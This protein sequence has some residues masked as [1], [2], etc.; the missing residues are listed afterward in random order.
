M[1]WTLIIEK[2]LSGSPWAM[3]VALGVYH[4]RVRAQD[5]AVIEKK[6]GVIE[7]KD[8]N[9]KQL[10]AEFKD[11]I[12]EMGQHVESVMENAHKEALELQETRVKETAESQRQLSTM[13]TRL[14]GT[15]QGLTTA[16]QS[17]GR[18]A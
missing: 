1:D 5:L 16:I 2:I 10:N 18:I 7:E 11:T 3:L 6:D 8:K 15:L 14:D 12:R 9:I 17:G 13:M 4:W